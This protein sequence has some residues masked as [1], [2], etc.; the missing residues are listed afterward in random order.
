MI[1]CRKRGA[2]AQEKYNTSNIYIAN[3]IPIRSDVSLSPRDLCPIAFKQLQLKLIHRWLASLLQVWARRVV[4]ASQFGFLLG[5]R[6]SDCL[7][8]AELSVW[9]C[10]GFRD[11]TAVLSLDLVNAFGSISRA[12]LRHVLVS[13]CGV[14][15]G[16]PLSAVV[17]V[18]ALDPFCRHLAMRLLSPCCIIAFADDLLLAVDS[19]G[20]A[21]VIFGCPPSP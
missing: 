20:R 11:D 12:W 14:P 17:F 21:V 9:Q 5:R 16:D 6:M 8:S 15:Q 13:Y 4:H 2:S 3:F 7:V 10:A 19:L 1:V 18:I